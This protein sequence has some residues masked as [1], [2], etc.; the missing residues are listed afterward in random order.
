MAQIILFKTCLA[1]VVTCNGT[2]KMQIVLHL[3]VPTLEALLVQMK[4]VDVI[5]SVGRGGH[6]MASVPTRKCRGL[7]KTGDDRYKVG[8]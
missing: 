7:S 5:S 3:T 8:A 4:F 6:A 1:G 2:N